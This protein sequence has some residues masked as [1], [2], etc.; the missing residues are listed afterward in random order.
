MC[1]YSIC[2]YM[3]HIAYIYTHKCLCLPPGL[4]SVALYSRNAKLK[5]PPKA[6]TEEFQVGKARLQM[7]LKHSRD[8]EVRLPAV[9]LKTGRKWKASQEMERAGE[10]VKFR[11]I[12]GATQV[13]RLGLGSGSQQRIWWS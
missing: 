7:M 2:I 1:I 10:A 9:K 4:T 13:G 6:L 11:E 3:L 8:P 5:L 12:L